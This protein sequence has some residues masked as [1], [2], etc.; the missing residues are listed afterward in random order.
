MH[1]FNEAIAAEGLQEATEIYRAEIVNM[2]DLLSRLSIPMTPEDKSLLR[3]QLAREQ[4]A[5]ERYCG[6]HLRSM[7]TLEKSTNI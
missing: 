7:A 2:K 1:A 4:D 3:E 5:H 6:A